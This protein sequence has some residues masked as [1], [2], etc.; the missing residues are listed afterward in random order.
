MARDEDAVRD[1]TAALD[2]DPTR[3]DPLRDRGLA[4][5]RMGRIEAALAD[6]A[7]HTDLGSPKRGRTWVLPSRPH[8]CY[9][10]CGGSEANRL[11]KLR[12]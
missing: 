3:T 6:L 5:I 8:L 1:F 9:T 10:F 11:Q 12:F 4:Y 2:L 7:G